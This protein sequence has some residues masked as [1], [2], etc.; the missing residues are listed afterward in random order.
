MVSPSLRLGWGAISL[1]AAGCFVDSVG[2]PPP[3]GGAPI[4]GGGGSATTF[5]GGAGTGGS[6]LVGGEGGTP[7]QGGEGGASLPN[8]GD[9]VVVSGEQCEDGNDVPKDGCTANCQFEATCN[10]SKLEPTEECD[11]EGPTCTSDCK[12]APGSGCSTAVAHQDAD[13]DETIEPDALPNPFPIPPFAGEWGPIDVCDI[14]NDVDNPTNVYRI[15]VGPYPEGVFIKVHGKSNVDPVLALH[16]GCGDTPNAPLFCHHA[17]DAFVVSDVVPA[18]SVMFAT[19]GDRADGGGFDM[20]LW[21]HRFWATFDTMTGFTADLATWAQGASETFTVNISDAD[22]SALVSPPIFV[23]NLASF[24][25]VSHYGFDTSDLKVAVSF[26]DGATWDQE[27]DLPAEGW[28]NPRWNS[29]VFENDTLQSF[30]LVRL[31]YVSTEVNGRA[32]VLAL[33][34]QPVAPFDTW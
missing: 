6:G 27:R 18:G 1:L 11:P 26:D 24:E 14:V 7:P 30:A 32:R 17:D 5:V 4:E 16:K 23:G 20:F 29:E 12:A 8:C 34:V 15:Q 2:V 25:V 13:T 28:D 19:V 33:R 31:R 9:G 10:N 3:I 22:G 21:F